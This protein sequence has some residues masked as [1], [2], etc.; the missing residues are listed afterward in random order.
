[1]TTDK[2]STSPPPHHHSL[3]VVHLA[4][5]SPGFLPEPLS[6]SDIHSVVVRVEGEDTGDNGVEVHGDSILWAKCSGKSEKDTPAAGVRAHIR[7]EHTCT[8]THTRTHHA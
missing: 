3:G 7:N 8:S 1:M 4:S 6:P 2:D 5:I